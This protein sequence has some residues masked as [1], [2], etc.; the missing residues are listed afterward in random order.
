MMYQQ[1]RLC[2]YKMQRMCADAMRDCTQSDLVKN[3][4]LPIYIEESIKKISFTEFSKLRKRARRSCFQ[5]SSGAE[6]L[7]FI[8][9]GSGRTDVQAF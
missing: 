5:E 7:F 1:V 8:F 3:S 4:T 6:S 9:Y 2:W